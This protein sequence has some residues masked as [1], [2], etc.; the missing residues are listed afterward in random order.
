M[1]YKSMNKYMEKIQK[2]CQNYKIENAV[3]LREKTLNI[4]CSVNLDEN[5]I[6][7]VCNVL[8]EKQNKIKSFNI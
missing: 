1:R 7:K 6:K 4:P 2:N 8:N 5:D 3:N